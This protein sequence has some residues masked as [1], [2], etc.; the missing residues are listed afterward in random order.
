MTSSS[1][2]GPVIRGD[3][4]QQ[5]SAVTFG[6][7]LRRAV[8]A[9]SKAVARIKEDART[10]GYAE[11]W[12]AGKRDAET[13]ALADR[14]RALADSA[15]FAERREA[16]LRRAIGALSVAADAAEQSLAVAAAELQD[17]ILAYAMELAEAIV[18]RELTDSDTRG[19]DA[20]RRALTLAPTAGPV[21][22]ALSPTDYA[23]LE[24]AD[25]EFTYEGRPLRLRPDPSLR[26][27]DATAEIGAMSVDA[28]V[29]T[30][31]ERAREALTR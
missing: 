5:A 9:D 6:T 22:V 7:D 10:A 11:G 23:A 8:P 20:I 30:A 18:G 15:A 21:I 31:I 25:G 2:R 12:A 16:A 28:T 17:L 4:A 13:A 29:A 3:S 26:P 27:G 24:I 19:V 14:E 1:D